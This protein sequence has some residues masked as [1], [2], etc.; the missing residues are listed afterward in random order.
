MEDDF[1]DVSMS[2]EV[3]ELHGRMLKEISIS[4]DICKSLFRALGQSNSDMD[5]ILQFGVLRSVSVEID[6]IACLVKILPL[7]NNLV[8]NTF[9]FHKIFR[10]SI[11]HVEQRVQH[12]SKAPRRPAKTLMWETKSLAGG[13]AV[14]TDGGKR[15][16]SNASVM[17]N[18]HIGKGVSVSIGMLDCFLICLTESGAVAQE[19]TSKKLQA[20][21]ND[22]MYHVEKIRNSA[23]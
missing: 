21:E 18:L 10:D 12:T 13:L 20:L 9:P 1:Y 17:V 6:N 3:S 14:S 7:P 8:A 2:A 22:L 16:E 23:V 15:W 19:V 4:L 11:C 5:D